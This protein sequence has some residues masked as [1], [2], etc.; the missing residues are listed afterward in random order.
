MKHLSP[1][2]EEEAN[3]WCRLSQILSSSRKNCRWLRRRPKMM[4]LAV[5]SSPAPQGHRRLFP[6]SNYGEWPMPVRSR[7]NFTPSIRLMLI[8]GHST[9]GSGRPIAGFRVDHSSHQ[10]RRNHVETLESSTA[11]DLPKGQRDFNRIFGLSIK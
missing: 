11:S 9:C 7:F 3:R 5:C 1:H 8:F 4:W 6:F 10:S 2:E